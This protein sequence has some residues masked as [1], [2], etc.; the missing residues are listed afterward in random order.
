MSEQVKVAGDN[1]PCEKCGNWHPAVY[2]AEISKLTAA[3]AKSK[4]EMEYFL[5]V[6]KVL[7]PDVQGLVS[8]L[9]KVTEQRDRL[10]AG[11]KEALMAASDRRFIL[12][13]IITACEQGGDNG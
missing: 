1:A 5:E 8:D 11:C 2:L 13:R 9:A 3:L 7:S 12:D 4:R 10:L 6:N